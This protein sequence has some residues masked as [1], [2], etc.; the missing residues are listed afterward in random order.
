M[1]EVVAGI[2][3]NVGV[4]YAEMNKY[5]EALGSLK[6]CLRIRGVIHGESHILY[7]QTIEK[8]GDVFLAMSDYDEAM[9][10]YDWALDVMHSDQP[11]GSIEPTQHR[12][13]MGCILENVGFIQYSKGQIDQALQ[14]YQEA[15]RSKQADLG[16]NHP[17]L[18]TIFHHIG[19]CLSDQGDTE[20]AS[21]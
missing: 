20:D 12:V 7:A 3:F 19:N 5:E 11:S 8:I 17:D 6:Q 14:S 10:S 2:Q 15:L 13:D 18:A 9:E 21:K 4:V 16:K 1:V